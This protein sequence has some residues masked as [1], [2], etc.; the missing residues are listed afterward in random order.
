M[1]ADTIDLD[2]APA[3]QPAQTLGTALLVL[4]GAAIVLGAFE[5][6][7]AWT[8]QARAVDV[9]RAVDSKVAVASERAVQPA[10]ANP[11]E[12]AR[13]RAVVKVAR[14]LQTPW[15]DLL[16]TLESAPHDGVALLIVEPSTTRQVVRVT[17]EA[18]NPQA[19][20]NYLGSLQS[21]QRLSQVLL[22]SHQVQANAS[23][24]PVRFQIQAGWGAVP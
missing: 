4:G 21:D 2:F 17:A 19:M 6:S 9:L 20:L 5:W 1:R 11:A 16:S 12:L 18:R 3:A 22:Q 14:S 24:A 23:G 7:D 15:S 13:D 10:A 8:S